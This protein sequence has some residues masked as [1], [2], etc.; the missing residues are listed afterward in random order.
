MMTYSLA[1][2]LTIGVAYLSLLFIVAY[3]SDSGVIPVRFLRHPIV[4]VLSLGVYVSAWAIFGAVGFAHDMGYEFLAYY[5]GIS[6]AF[7]LSPILL[8]PVLRLARTY[9][10]GSLADLFAYR[11]R[12]QALGA[13]TSLAMTVSVMPLLA[14]QIQAVADSIGLMTHQDQPN[15]LA[16]W[17]C[18]IITV[19]TLL[20]GTRHITPR[21]K[22]EGL[23]VAIAL[24]SLIKLVA[25]LCLGAFAYFHVLGGAA[26]LKHW[27]ND[28]PQNLQILYTPLH[29]GSWHSLMLAFFFSA[30]LMP[31]MY[32]MS[33]TE[34]QNP[35]HL[36]RAS[37]GF[38]LYLLLAA[39]PVPLILWAG[40]KLV[41][42]EV[43]P[44]YF[45][46]AVAMA[47]HTPLLTMLVFIAG[48]SAASG[49]IIV[50]TLALASMNLSHLVLPIYA[51]PQ[52]ANLYD[53]LLRMR[54]RLIVA[55]ISIAYAL[56]IAL[57]KQHTLTEMGTITFVGT[58]QFAPGLVG[59]LFWPR[60]NRQGL[61]WGLSVGMSIWFIAMVLPFLLQI[62][63][64]HFR[65]G[66]IE[67]TGNPSY[68]QDVGVTATF[69]NSL[70][71]TLVSLLT[72][73]SEV[74][75]MA[76]AT[77]S[78]DNLRR[79]QRWEL[80][81]HK[82]EEFI[83]ALAPHL[84]SLSAESEVQGALK[85]LQ[86][87]GQE[88]RPYALRRLRDQLESNLSGLLGPAIAQ[89][90]LDQAIPYKIRAEQS[91][92][93][94]IH[95]TESRLEEYRNK[96]SGLAAKFDSLRRFHRQT[97]F[98][99]PIGVFTLGKDQE[100]L[101]W[102]QAMMRLTG[103]TDRDVIGSHLHALPAP[104][105]T[106]FVGYI[107]G[108]LAAR[109][110]HHIEFQGQQRWV[111]MNR[112]LIVG[113]D[114]VMDD[115]QV[116]VVEDVTAMHS[117]EA[118]L[119]H[120]ER[121]VSIGTFAAGIAHEIGNPITAI[122][123]LAQN[124]RAE[125]IDPEVGEASTQIIEQTQRISRTVQ[126]LVVFARGGT[127]HSNHHESVH[128]HSC[129]EESIRLLQLVPG[130]RDYHFSNDCDVDAYA[131]GDQQELMQVFVNLLSNARDAS[132]LGGHII[133][134]CHGNEH[135]LTIEV[136]DFGSGLSAAIRPHLF[137]PFATTK[138]IG[139]GTG[140]GLA[141]IHGII[142]AHHGKIQMIDKA[143]YDQ[144]RGVIAR[145]TLPGQIAQ[146]SGAHYG[147]YPH[148]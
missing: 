52:E 21:E 99:L 25:L 146:Q 97:L 91:V 123:C 78:V 71:F 102:N 49:V 40:I 10:L 22:H 139:K 14:M 38:P 13:F 142:G 132:P 35:Q 89:D 28:N 136:E 118:Q 58:L 134:R 32:Q 54:R 135:N 100:I 50:A 46:L 9:H 113:E 16:L 94:D 144:G 88:S 7:L 27:L 20:F 43:D 67:F 143:D 41:N 51:P 18:L 130:G 90:L 60:G 6:G 17:F 73:Q 140:L 19:F 148:R 115:G 116:V 74:E 29:E 106:L 103:I 59:V 62:E 86:M 80:S 36:K 61:A 126:S 84:G 24:E 92:G 12:S 56:F 2:I 101:S 69:V 129:V 98:D 145:I 5:I 63:L 33:F 72:R 124:L 127:T 66:N 11:Y 45:S 77:C 47:A 42:Y 31:F 120:R 93:E 64:F 131:H 111:S 122:A 65:F 108:N 15:T 1:N 8:G 83:T 70:V 75:A 141:L 23:V 39:L 81:L 53:W 85:E 4:Y 110:R 147:D 34:N 117:M 79:P 30:V 114:L 48:L 109:P 55:L 87:Q 68:W 125:N 26:G 133:I 82:A 44:E 76:A 121:L 128:I 37:W 96:L 138:E 57:D 137:E 104:W 105:G 119:T 107:D 112:A 95:Y 3:I